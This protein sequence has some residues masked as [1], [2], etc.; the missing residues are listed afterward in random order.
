MRCTSHGRH[1]LRRASVGVARWRWL[2]VRFFGCMW[3]NWSLFFLFASCDMSSSSTPS[4]AP[5]QRGTRRSRG[6]GRPSRATK[7]KEHSHDQEHTPSHHHASD[8]KSSR[9]F[10]AKLTHQKEAS[11]PSPPPT[12][13]EYTDLRSRIVTEISQ[14]EY[15]CIICYNAIKRKHPIWSCTR[16]Y[17]VL[18]LSL[19]H[20]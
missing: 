13:R 2:Q 9:K 18:H 3:K 11:A 12:V 17:A 5:P 8:R 14:G 19:I 15:D 1:G 6:R 20:I 4:S 16:C 7:N 10:G